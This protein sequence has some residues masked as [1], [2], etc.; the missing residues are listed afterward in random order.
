MGDNDDRAPL[1]YPL[2]CFLDIKIPL[3]YPERQSVRPGSG[4][5]RLTRA[6]GP[7]RSAA[8]DPPTNRHPARLWGSDNPR[9]MPQQSHGYE[10]L[11]P[12]LLHPARE[13][14]RQKS[15]YPGCSPETNC[16]PAWRNRPG[17]APTP[18][19]TAGCRIRPGRYIPRRDRKNAES[20]AP[21]WTCPSHFGPPAPW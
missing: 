14:L 16:S 13:Y 10:Q 1:S 18:G 2:Q 12:R 5:A 21:E 6:P 3:L 15:D 8:F 4:S 11:A 7:A 9:A 17:D 19:G 20:I